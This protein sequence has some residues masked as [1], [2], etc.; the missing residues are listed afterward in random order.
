[1]CVVKLLMQLKTGLG[2]LEEAIPAPSAACRMNRGATTVTIP[3]MSAGS[4]V[5][6]LAHSN[7][8]TASMSAAQVTPIE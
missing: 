1:V 6:F 2:V 7:P 8:P 4:K 3:L 5:G